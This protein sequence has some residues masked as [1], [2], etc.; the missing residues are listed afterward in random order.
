MRGGEGWLAINNKRGLPAAAVL[1]WKPHPDPYQG[2]RLHPIHPTALSHG[3]RPPAPE[4][5]HIE[6]HQS[7]PA[8]VQ[9]SP[10]L[11]TPASLVKVSF[12]MWGFSDSV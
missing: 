8:A 7:P 6:Q 12:W 10:A 4:L 11:T 3:S 9:S 5:I 1:G 2:A